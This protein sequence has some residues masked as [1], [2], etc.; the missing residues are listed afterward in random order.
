M[1]MHLHRFL[2]AKLLMDSLAHHS[3]RQAV[4]NALETL[5]A[6]VNATYNLA[7]ERI[8]MQGEYDR[9]LAERVLSWISF[10]YRPLSLKELQTA[11]AVS[12]GISTINSDDFEDE[13]ILTSVCAGLVVID[14]TSN[15]IRLVR[16]WLSSCFIPRT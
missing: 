11:F 8:A 13:L 16:K 6:G 5:P 14:E 9:A 1:L 10:A 12:A 4:R 15:I 3:N 7:M 2:L